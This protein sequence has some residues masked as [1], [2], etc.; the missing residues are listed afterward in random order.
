MIQWFPVLYRPK[1][2]SAYMLPGESKLRGVTQENITETV[3]LKKGL[4]KSFQRLP[5]PFP[6]TCSLNIW[7]VAIC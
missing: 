5:S 6:V 1:E 4:R 2:F 3:Q 7:M